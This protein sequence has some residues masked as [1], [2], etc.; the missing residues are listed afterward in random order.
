MAAAPILTQGLGSFGGVA[1]LPTLGFGAGVD[2]PPSGTVGIELTAPAARLHYKA[3]ADRLHFAAPAASMHYTATAA[4][5]HFVAPAARL[6]FTAEE[7]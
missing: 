7:S 2:S 3:P 1:L 4:R 5:L 6:H